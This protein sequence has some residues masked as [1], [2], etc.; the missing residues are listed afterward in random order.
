[1]NDQ[2]LIHEPR[3]ENLLGQL[4]TRYSHLI[5]QLPI[6]LQQIALAESTYLGENT[7][8]PFSGLRAMNPLI[9]RTPW[10]FWKVFKPLEDE[11]FLGIAEAGVCMALASVFIDHLVD[12][13]VPEPGPFMLFR[14]SL[15]DR[16]NFLYRQIF[17]FKSQFWVQYERLTRGHITSLQ[18]EI[19]ARTKTELFAFD[20]FTDFAG[21]KVAPMAITIAALTEASH[22]PDLLQPIETSIRCSYVAGQLHDDILD[23]EPDLEERHLS[24]FLTCLAADKT[25]D[26][27]SWPTHTEL[28]QVNNKEWVDVKSYYQAIEWFDRAL[29]AVSGIDCPGWKHYLQE[30]RGVAEKDQQSALASHLLYVLDSS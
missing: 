6:S 23:W 24:Y 27:G 17:P 2:E 25:F 16:G 21:G 26:R 29:Q 7:Q 9:T 5:D 28:Q 4:E 22:Q 3:A 1:M 15:C 12:G 8:K 18:M 20:N 11:I 10:L 14:Q 19:D 30:Y 13:Q